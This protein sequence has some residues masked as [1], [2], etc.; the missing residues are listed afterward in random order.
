ML[1]ILTKTIKA[2]NSFLQKIIIPFILTHFVLANVY[3]IGSHRSQ[4]KLIIKS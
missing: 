1:L 3:Y 4:I 2:C